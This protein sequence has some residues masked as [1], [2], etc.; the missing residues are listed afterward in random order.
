[1]QKLV[2]SE[3]FFAAPTLKCEMRGG[4]RVFPT[5]STILVVAS[6]LYINT[7]LVEVRKMC[8]GTDSGA[9]SRAWAERFG[10][11]E[12]GTHAMEVRC[13]TRRLE[14]WKIGRLEDWKIG[15]LEDWKIG[16][17]EDWKIGRLEVTF[18]LWQSSFETSVC[19]REE[20]N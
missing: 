12:A 8:V 5:V 11:A 20:T 3:S 10:A 16:R 1:M 18:Y 19:G 6:R 13:R 2:G 7:N 17:L 14:D 15:R 9:Y 4:Q